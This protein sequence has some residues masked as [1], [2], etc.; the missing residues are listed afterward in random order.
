MISKISN[1]LIIWQATHKQLLCEHAQYRKRFRAYI[2]TNLCLSC[3]LLPFY[4]SFLG[5][6]L[7]GFPANLCLILIVAACIFCLTLRQFHFQ[8]QSIR[9][10]LKTK[11][12]A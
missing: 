12:K 8:R 4:L 1:R 3:L 2:T 11:Q 9:Q 10:F 5:A 7:F 6:G